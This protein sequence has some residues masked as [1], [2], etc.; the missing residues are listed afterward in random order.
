MTVCVCVCVRLDAAGSRLS[1]TCVRYTG[2]RRSCAEEFEARFLRR[3]G[4]DLSRFLLKEGSCCD[5]LRVTNR[6]LN[7][8]FR[9]LSLG[10]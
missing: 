4:S 9:K 1:S 3:L 8:G 7:L 5:L 10:L 6:L 2:L